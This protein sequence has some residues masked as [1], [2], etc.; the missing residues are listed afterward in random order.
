MKKV[1]LIFCMLIMG[2]ASAQAQNEIPAYK[3]DDLNSRISNEDTVYIVN[4]W[5]TWCMPCVQELPE[6]AELQKYYEGQKVKIIMV[7]LD[8]KEDYPLR[9]STFL[10]RK[11]MTNEVVWLNEDKP[12]KFI[13]KIE[14][15]WTGSIPATMI[16]KANKKKFIERQ[17]TKDELIEMVNLVS[18]E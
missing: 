18:A 15:Q 14:P 8:F 12:N 17:T 6:F 9:L 2:L 10:Q 5:A 13:N 11:R 7:S 16:V 3:V 4:F 1:G